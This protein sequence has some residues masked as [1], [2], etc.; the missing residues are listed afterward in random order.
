MR[1]ILNRLSRAGD[2]IVRFCGEKR[3]YD[4]EFGSAKDMFCV[5]TLAKLLP[6]EFF[7]NAHG[8]FVNR[9]S[10][11]FVIEAAPLV[12]GDEHHQK[13]LSSLFE[14]FFW[15]G[16]SLQF[17]LLA[18]HRI[19]PFLN[20]WSQGKNEGIFR[21]IVNHRKD[22]Y[23]KGQF[24]SRNFRFFLSYSVPFSGDYSKEAE[25]LNSMRGKFLHL[26]Q[27][28][29]R[30]EGMGPQTFLETAD[31]ML[32]FNA[33]SEFKRR[34]HNPLDDLST[35][36]MTGGETKIENDGVHFDEKSVFMSFCAK[37]TP[38]YWTA[39][40]MQNL[41]GDTMRDN[42]RM[43][44]PFF[45]H[46]GVHYPNQ[47][48]AEKN[49]NMKSKLIE[50]QGKSGYLIRMIPELASEL[51][52][53]D[54][55]RRSLAQGAKFVFTQF[56]C[57]FWAPK[58]KLL[59]AEQSL[60][61]LFK[62]NRFDLTENRYM[63]FAHLVSIIPTAWGEMATDLKKMDLLKTT[64]STECPHFIPIQGEWGGTSNPGMLLIGRRGQMLNWSPFNNKG[65]NFNAIVVGS[66]G[67]GKSVFMQDMLLNGLRV[68]SKVFILDVGRS[69][70]KMCDLVGGQKIEFSNDSNICLNPFSQIVINDQEQKETTFSFLKTIVSCMASPSQGTTDYENSLIESA[71]QV[72]CE[73]YGQEGTITDLA[74]ELQS[75]MDEKARILSVMLKPYTKGGMYEKYFEGKNNINFNNPL[76]LIEL[77]E[78]KNKK[79]LQRVI[80]QL[81]IMTIANQAFLGDRKTPFYICIDEAWD[82]LRAPQTVEFIETLARRLRKYQGSLVVGTQNIED[83]FTT[84]GAKAAYDNSDW[85][86]FLSQ[87]KDSIQYLTESGKLQ[88]NPG[89]IKALESVF[90]IPGEFSEIL[91]SDANG[92]YSIAR[93]MLDPFSKLLYSTKAEDFSRIKDLTQ[94]GLSIS[95]AINTL[96]GT[97]K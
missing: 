83:F 94:S 59:E 86:C 6:F 77:E 43:N 38:D 79:D 60:Q 90:Y 88:R 12:G 48:Q 41:I 51:R 17:L 19:Q 55:V 75:M 68:G 37:N 54:I 9:H 39:Q 78:L 81:V 11:G 52:E 42:Y 72:V 61:N 57:G 97:E 4:P 26:F 27:A 25:R 7:D 89:M 16:A 8:L 93:L 18:D 64:I 69:F 10:I 35:Q 82:L 74:K 2:K 73:K 14:D 46:Y 15:E 84:P 20:W 91:I 92:G 30:A 96:L 70:E 32:N 85:N 40:N 5:D 21:E 63:H 44:F 50:S 95:E 36:L 62:A 47:T 31:Y 76:V 87:K 49:F 66:S 28:I 3:R 29:T 53:C 23:K 34:K 13:L 33:T 22:Y 45:L 58:E 67:S 1:R 65:G 56:S 24:A 80:L 71:L